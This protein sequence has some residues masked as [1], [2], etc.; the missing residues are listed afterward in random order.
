M[1][2][3]TFFNLLLRYLFG[4]F[5]TSPRP[6]GF[7]NPAIFDNFGDDG[8]KTVQLQERLN[9]AKVQNQFLFLPYNPG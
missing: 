7:G 8:Y 9:V 1:Q 3:I 6:Y 5:D 2:M 4:K